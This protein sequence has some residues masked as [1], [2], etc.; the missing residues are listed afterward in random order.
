MAGFALPFDEDGLNA[1]VDLVA[2]RVADVVIG[3][4]P[5]GN[6]S[7]WMTSVEAVEYLRLSSVDSLHRLTA[8]GAV[9]HYKVNGRNLFSKVE[10]DGWVRDNYA[11][12]PRYSPGDR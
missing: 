4:L 3:R 12:P 8:A 11:G 6:G 5:S 10:L 2:L 7:D 9:P 1:L